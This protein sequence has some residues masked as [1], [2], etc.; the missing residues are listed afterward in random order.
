[1]SVKGA[2]N[3]IGHDADV[4]IPRLVSSLE[5]AAIMYNDHYCKLILNLNEISIGRLPSQFHL[6]QG[7]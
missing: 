3:N 6:G 5:T 1:M 7:P 2:I 4:K